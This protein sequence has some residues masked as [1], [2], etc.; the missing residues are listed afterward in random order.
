MQLAKAD[1]ASVCEIKC[2][3][4]VQYG[5][6]II[7]NQSLSSTPRV[8]NTP[9]TIPRPYPIMTQIS[10][11][12]IFDSLETAQTD[13]EEPGKTFPSIAPCA[14][15]LELLECFK[16]LQEM[17]IKSNQLDVRFDTLPR[18]NLTSS[19]VKNREGPRVLRWRL[20]RPMKAHDSNFQ[21]RQKVKWTS[22]LLLVERANGLR[23]VS[24]YTSS[25]REG[26]NRDDLASDSLDLPEP[27]FATIESALQYEIAMSLDWGVGDVLAV[28]KLAWDLYHKCYKVAKD[29]P[30]DFRQLVN[31]LAS[32][33]GVL[34]TLRDDANSNDSFTRRLDDG[35]K[36]RLE[37]CIQ[38]CHDTLRN[39]KKLVNKYQELDGGD[40]KQFRR[41]LQWVTE[42]GHIADFR[43]RIMVHTYT[44]NL[45]MSSIGNSALARIENYLMKALERQGASEETAEPAEDLTPITPSQ[46]TP[47]VTDP[48]D[49]SKPLPPSP[50][51]YED[52][53]EDPLKRRPRRVPT[54]AGRQAK[55]LGKDEAGR[56]HSVAEAVEEA[57]QELLKVRQRDQA[58]RP[59]RIVEEDPLHTVDD[60]LKERFQ[61]LADEDLRIRR[62]SAKDWLRIA[63][64]WLLKARFNMRDV[65][66]SSPAASGSIQISGAAGGSANQAYVDLLKS[67]WILRTV[68]LGETNISSLMTDENRKLVYNLSD[69]INESFSKIQPLD[70]HGR[71]ALAEQNIDIW[72]LLQ[73]EEETFHED[74]LLGGLNNQRWITV[75]KDDGGEEEETVLYRTFVNA[76]I[77]G[78]RYRIKSRGAPYM[79]ILST[80]AGESQPKVTICNQIGTM[81]MTRDFTPDDLQ[82]ENAMRSQ[83]HGDIENKEGLPLKFGRM[84]VT[85]SFTNQEDQQGFMNL[86]RSYFNAIKRR[87]PRQ[88]EKAT[89]ALLFDCSVETFEQLKPLTLKPVNP[90]QQLRSCNLQI[91]ETTCKEGWRTTRRL[92]VSPSACEKQPRCTELFL[93][94]SNVSISREGTAR[95]AI[96][97]WSDCLHEH[98]DTTD[99]NYN[100]I[101]NYV[102][103][104]N[105]PNRA[106]SLLFRTS[107][108]AA[109][110]ENT[111]LK[112]STPPVMFW[113]NEHD[114]RHVYNISNT[115]PPKN[116][117]GILV[118]HTHLGWKYSELFHMYR[119]TDY[120]YD[121]TP[122]RVRFPQIQYTHYV[123][124]HFDKAYKPDPGTPPHFSHCDKRMGTATVDLGSEHLAFK[125]MSALTPG[126]EL[127]FSRRATY[128]ATKKKAPRKWRA[129]KGGPAEVQLW[130]KN[131]DGT[132][133]RLLML[134]RWT[135]EEDTAVEDKWLGL[136]IE[137]GAAMVHD[138]KRVSFPKTSS[139]TR[140]RKLDMA[141]LQPRDPKGMR[142]GKTRNGPVTIYFESVGDREAFAAAVAAA[143]GTAAGKRERSPLDALMDDG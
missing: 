87:E 64:W 57:N 139:Y 130:R 48:V 30:D 143:G 122:A 74:G 77:G 115:E 126:H 105:D 42:K 66:S 27:A 113:S 69:G 38:S 123:S 141:G 28:T 75:E 54:A 17:V 90:R 101:Y 136:Q 120:I 82:N 96:V 142:E 83:T 100:R 71:Q 80:K 73:P 91:L 18:N 60:T 85:V 116:Y 52:Y 111:V 131:H 86:P 35:R 61:Q 81:S 37:M 40:G 22:F 121:H 67:S 107:A 72:E 79:L 88:L 135:E 84:N 44:I 59:L 4:S 41:K 51:P 112:L 45:H 110:F 55:H 6:F 78:K 1:A 9:C 15:H 118:T 53:D 39:L 68:I 133:T 103:D 128:L 137:R 43:A 24:G 124:S 34:R 132:E 58:A 102:Y 56:P 109:D 8:D 19:N 76:A 7:L 129:S 12:A 3:C 47:A 49:V 20:L 16:L 95:S 93:P 11:P 25:S 138:G 10:L 2:L 65:E 106:I 13:E 70:E 140:G 14:V 97:K 23:A 125:F 108:G 26:E 62:L 33:E 29:A 63:T 94:L 98:S 114:S 119:D 117:K 89:E 36:E 104:E 46:T 50:L 31:E 127:L 5:F 32:L 92:V 134:A 21:K 99:G